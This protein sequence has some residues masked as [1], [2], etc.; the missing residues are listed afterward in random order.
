MF[1]EQLKKDISAIFLNLKEFG[2]LIDLNGQE[3]AAVLEDLELSADSSREGVSY[4]GLTVYTKA[5]CLLYT[6]TPHKSC[7]INGEQWFVLS[8]N[9]DCGLAVIKLYREKN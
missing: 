2:E 8:S 5:D 7:F 4:E 6:Y 1:K 9:N 3:V